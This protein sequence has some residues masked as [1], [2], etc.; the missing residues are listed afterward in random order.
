MDARNTSLLIGLCSLILMPL[1]LLVWKK[2]TKN[3]MLEISPDE[4]SE[5]K[6]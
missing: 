1:I 6:R 5:E 4:F 2:L 3:K